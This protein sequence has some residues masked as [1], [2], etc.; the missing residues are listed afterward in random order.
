MPP[1]RNEEEAEWHSIFPDSPQ[2][3]GEVWA[4]RLIM[5]MQIHALHEQDPTNRR[6]WGDPSDSKIPSEMMSEYYGFIDAQRDLGVRELS[7]SAFDQV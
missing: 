3:Q 1:P 2:E 4:S 6:L 7:P 5:T